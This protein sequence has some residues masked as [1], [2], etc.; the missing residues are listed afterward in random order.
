MELGIDIEKIRVLFKQKNFCKFCLELLSRKISLM[1]FFVAVLTAGYCVYLW[2]NFIFRPE[3]SEVKKQE[4]INSK[5]K[6]IVFNRS[7]FQ[8]IIDEFKSREGQSQKNISD[9]TDIFRVKK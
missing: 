4:Y 1:V 6:G 8:N 7:R 5:D 3:W 9:L 2:Y